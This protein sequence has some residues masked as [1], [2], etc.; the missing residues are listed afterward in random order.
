MLIKSAHKNWKKAKK[1]FKSHQTRYTTIFDAFLKLCKNEGDVDVRNMLPDSRKKILNQNKT[2]LSQGIKVV[3]FCR[4]LERISK[5]QDGS[6]VGRT[7]SFCGEYSQLF[8][9]KVCAFLSYSNHKQVFLFKVFCFHTF[10]PTL[11]KI[12]AEPLDRDGRKDGA[13]F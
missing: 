8:N 13:R 6:L 3:E 10:S 7:P 11:R 1:D 5:K 9:H 12:L 4:R 2:L